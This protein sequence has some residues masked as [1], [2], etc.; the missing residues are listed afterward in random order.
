[1]RENRI[2]QQPHNK[3]KVNANE[4]KVAIIAIISV[5]GVKSILKPLIASKIKNPGIALSKEN[6]KLAFK[7]LPL[8]LRYI[9]LKA[10]Q[11]EKIT[12]EIK[13]NP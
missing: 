12:T 1:M 9:S 6:C 11:L 7:L 8:T 3:E 5:N 4:F 2:K 10:K 13:I